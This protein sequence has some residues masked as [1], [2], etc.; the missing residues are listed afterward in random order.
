MKSI[1]K[2]ITILAV[3]LQTSVFAQTGDASAQSTNTASGNQWQNWI[4]A[5]GALIVAGGGL[6]A[7]AVDSGDK[8]STSHD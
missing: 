1:N 8:V 5:A 4:F 6:I 3:F 2:Q 7:V